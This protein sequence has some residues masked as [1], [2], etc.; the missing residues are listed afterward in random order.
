MQEP[1]V[2]RI[3]DAASERL[4]Q[5]TVF[6]INILHSPDSPWQNYMKSYCKRFQSENL[7]S[8]P[9]LPRGR[10]QWVRAPDGEDYGAHPI[11]GSH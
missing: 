3:I 2:K 5:F 4:P 9:K 6:K 8:Q 10:N 11:P 1:G 7:A